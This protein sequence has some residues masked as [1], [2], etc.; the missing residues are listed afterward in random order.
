MDI[1]V[2]LVDGTGEGN[3]DIYEVMDDINIVLEK[4]DLRVKQFGEWERFVNSC[5][6]EKE[7]IENLIN[8]I[9]VEDEN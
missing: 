2:R 8:I 3:F 4:H 7:F 1:G 9:G 5:I 6:K